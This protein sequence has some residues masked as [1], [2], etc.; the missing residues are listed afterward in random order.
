MRCLALAPALI[1]LLA[2]A[3]AAPPVEAASTWTAPIGTSWGEAKI[4]TGTSTRLVIAAKNLRARTAY[5]IALR[6]G[7][8]STLGTLVVSRRMTASIYGKITTSFALTTTQARLAKLPLTIRLG[9]RCGA[10]KAPP[11]PLP[12]GAFSDGTYRVGMVVQPGTYRAVPSSICYWERL[13]GFG[14]TFDEIIANDYGGGPRIVTIV[15][16]DA[17]FKSSGCGIWKLQP[18]VVAP[19][20]VGT[21]GQGVWRV[22]VDIL[23]GTYQSTSDTSCYWA[24]RSGFSGVFDEIIANDYGSGPRLLTVDPTDVGVETSGCGPWTLIP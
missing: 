7:S 9:T 23:P 3:I 5:T 21:F 18:E 10:F 13:S 8:C 2:V 11:P 15:P 22:N 1:A 14:G 24:R 12:S 6:R 19:V 4:V 20:P 17:G 16:T